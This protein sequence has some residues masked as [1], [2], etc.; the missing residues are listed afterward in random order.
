MGR[1]RPQR[2]RRA[3]KALRR[4]PGARQF[5]AILS[6]VAA[7]AVVVA[8]FGSCSRTVELEPASVGAPSIRVLLLDG[9][10]A[11]DV[12]VAG[13]Y[14]ILLIDGS[15][16][17]RR[18]ASGEE[19]GTQRVRCVKADVVVGDVIRTPRPVEF[20][21]RSVPVTLDGRRYRGS[22][23]ISSHRGKVRVVNVL[24]IDGYLRGV[25][26]REMFPRWPLPALEAQAIAARSYALAKIHRSS[27]RAFDVYTSVADQKYGG[28]DDE[29]ART[30]AAVASTAGF[31][32]RY[33]AR[34]L[35]AYYHAC[36][37][38]STADA[39]E[40]FDDP[41][42]PLRGVQCG[43]CSDAPRYKWTARIPRRDAARKLGVKNLNGLSL[44]GIGLDGRVG[45]VTLHRSTGSPLVMAG[46]TFRRRM[47]L[48]ST[49]FKV[50]VDGADFVFDGR[51][52]GHGVGLCQWGAKGMADTGKSYKQILEQYYPGAK[53][54]RMY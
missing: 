34:V 32:L 30:D 20:V 1:T 50:K 8:V 42:P 13:P 39:R 37:G 24:D 49:R 7:A 19:L 5:F 52:W 41:A 45:Q 35:T 26:A 46:T 18:L 29:T 6:K 53:V 12:S 21:G 15:G 40:V 2:Q 43:Y 10:D 47:G 4:N 16:E 44:E 3:P 27:G 33:G 31:A 25:V 36:C 14:E 11:V 23:R 51:G 17:R 22:V 38:G 28:F 9:K 48:N 54:A